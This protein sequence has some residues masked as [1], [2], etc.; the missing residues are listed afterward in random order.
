MNV[1]II[2]R[3]ATLLVFYFCFETMT[4]NCFIVLLSKTFF[5]TTYI[6][7]SSKYVI[8]SFFEWSL[9]KFNNSVMNVDILTQCNLNTMSPPFR[10]KIHYSN[11]EISFERYMFFITFSLIQPNRGQSSNQLFAMQQKKAQ[12]LYWPLEK[13]E[14][15]ENMK[16]TWESSGTQRNCGWK[17]WI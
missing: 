9:S 11:R 3:L 6:T 8:I 10:Y 17:I 15:I 4:T 5:I 2:Y 12:E 1:T 16:G 7:R 13:Q 14:S